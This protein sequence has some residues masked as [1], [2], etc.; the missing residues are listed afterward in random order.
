MVPSLIFFWALSIIVN[1]YEIPS[2]YPLDHECENIIFSVEFWFKNFARTVQELVK[3]Q[4][5]FIFD[6]SH[7]IMA[8]VFVA[9]QLV[10]YF[11]SW[12]GNLFF[13]FSIF[14]FLKA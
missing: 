13:F 8:K 6:I 14:A 2:I 5:G 3:Q 4:N 7:L 9:Y 10:V 12:E 11:Y 1:N